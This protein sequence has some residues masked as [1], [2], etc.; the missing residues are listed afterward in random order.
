MRLCPIKRGYVAVHVAVVAQLHN[1]PL[2]IPQER[3][4]TSSL[5]CQHLVMGGVERKIKHRV[6][7]ENPGTSSQSKNQYSMNDSRISQARSESVGHLICCGLI[8]LV[9]A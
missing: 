5:H 8:A 9:R 6:P 3:R 7:V 2:L 4:E 1:F